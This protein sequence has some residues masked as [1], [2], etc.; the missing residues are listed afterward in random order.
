MFRLA[1]VIIETANRGPMLD[2]KINTIDATDEKDSG[3]CPLNLE[4]D[5]EMPIRLGLAE[6]L[7]RGN[8]CTKSN[9]LSFQWGIPGTKGQFFMDSFFIL[10]SPQTC[11]IVK[12]SL[13]LQKC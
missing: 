13:F 11:N 9:I 12:L 7:R 2:K 10:L 4:S 3:K 8:C 5:K 1:K 6:S